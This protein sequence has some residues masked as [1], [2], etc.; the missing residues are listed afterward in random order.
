MSHR[1]LKLRPCPQCGEPGGLICCP[2]CHDPWVCELCGQRLGRPEE[3]CNSGIHV[4][5]SGSTVGLAVRLSASRFERVVELDTSPWRQ[6]H[7][8]KTLAVGF[9][10]VIH[11]EDGTPVAGSWVA[12][13]TLAERY[14]IVVY[15]LRD[16]LDPVVS[17]LDTHGFGRYFSEVTDRRPKAWAYVDDRAYV[18]E[19]AVWF[20][21]WDQALTQLEGISR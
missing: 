19:R 14:R 6:R 5:P 13:G 17:W 15:A 4:G 7:L 20:E 11:G 18:D 9:D 12:L 8:L 2:N 16:N 10:G 3:Q 21:T 1:R